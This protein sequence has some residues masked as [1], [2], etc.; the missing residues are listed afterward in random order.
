MK[1]PALN[2]T[3]SALLTLAV[4]ACS[5]APITPKSALREAILNGDV[6]VAHVTKPAQLSE[7]TKTQAIANL[8]VSNVVGNVAG[9]AGDA[10]SLQQL[11][12]NMKLGQ[13]LSMELQKALPDNYSVSA[14]KG[15]DLALAKKLSDYLGKLAPSSAPNKRELSIAVNTSLWELGYVSFLTSQ[16]YALNYNLQMTVSEQNEDKQQTLTTINCTN[17]AKEKMPLEKWRAENY[18]AVDTSAEII[19]NTCFSQF[20]AETGLD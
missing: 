19:V 6:S 8:V 18:K 12:E 14:G 3:L 9:N 15:A 7:R 20:L 5:T 10:Q 1:T 4:T 13:T 17:S 2:F 11:Q 16:D